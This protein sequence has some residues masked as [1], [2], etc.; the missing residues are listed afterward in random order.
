MGNRYTCCTADWKWFRLGE[1]GILNKFGGG[2]IESGLIVMGVQLRGHRHTML[3]YEWKVE[4]PQI[5]AFHLCPA[6][7]TKRVLFLVSESWDARQAIDAR[8]DATKR[9]EMGTCTDV[10]RIFQL[11]DAGSVTPSLT[12]RWVP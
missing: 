4:T 8:L 7:K 1:C 12:A 2:P 9:K 11:H 10:T 5:L 6:N 3:P